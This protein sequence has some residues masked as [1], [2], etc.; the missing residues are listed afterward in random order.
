MMCTVSRLLA[1]CNNQ[2]TAD[3]GARD[4]VSPLGNGILSSLLQTKAADPPSWYTLAAPIS[5][6]ATKDC[7]SLLTLPFL[8]SIPLLLTLRHPN[9]LDQGSGVCM[10]ALRGPAA[11]SGAQGATDCDMR[12]RREEGAWRNLLPLQ[13]QLRGLR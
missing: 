10:A 12:D 13:P 5:T 1:F 7:G 4:K 11:R 3:G 9:T 8:G 2:P 6:A